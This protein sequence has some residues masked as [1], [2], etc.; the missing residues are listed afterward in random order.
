VEAGRLRVGG[1]PRI[2]LTRPYLK[3]EIKTKELKGI[4]HV[5]ESLSSKC[6]ALSSF[7]KTEKKK[8]TI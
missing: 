6:E 5:V 7:P 2:K 4:D 8:K 3:N 1:H